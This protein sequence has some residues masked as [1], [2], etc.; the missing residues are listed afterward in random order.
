V[1]DAPRHLELTATPAAGSATTL[2]LE[3]M[4]LYTQF[5][6]CRF[7]SSFHRR[8]VHAGVVR[9]VAEGRD[10]SCI[11]YH[12]FNG[13]DPVGEVIAAQIASFERLGKHFEWKVYA[14][15]QPT[16]LGDELLRQ[17]FRR[18][19][20]EAFMVLDLGTAPA[21]LYESSCPHDVRR[22]TRPTEIAD[23]MA[24]QEAIAGG[25]MHDRTEALTTELER[26]PQRISVYV[27]YA[28]GTPVASAWISF[29][30]ASPFAGL[31]GGATL[32]EY[33]RSGCYHALIAARA[34]EA[35]RR[36][37]SYLTI[38]AS[39]MSRPIVAGLGFRF[40]A[41]TWPYEWRCARKRRSG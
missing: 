23:A 5:E 28:D 6:R 24:V 15:D 21:P 16:T 2:E 36:G 35:R 40:V 32:P 30:P 31:W 8:D 39:P 41:E 19:P 9:Y 27:V 11:L 33:R 4:Q 37:I 26:N 20:G 17:G 25:P 38:D 14:T 7:V 18:G 29:N 22:V 1:E 10:G 13:D 12:D 34:R 3:L